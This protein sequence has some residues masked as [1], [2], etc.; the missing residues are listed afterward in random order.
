[1]YYL[2]PDPEAAR[3]YLESRRWPDGVRCP[4]CG[5]DHVT[6]RKGGFYR[7]RACE[8][9]ENF[10]VRT[11]TVMERSH[12]PLDAWCVAMLLCAQEPTIPGA[13]LAAQLG[14]TRKTASLVRAR[15]MEALDFTAE[16]LA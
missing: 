13:A 5:G 14:V 3:L 1:M 16:A 9:G 10:T 7:C 6:V 12:V 15:I 8:A 11:G 2:F 4:F